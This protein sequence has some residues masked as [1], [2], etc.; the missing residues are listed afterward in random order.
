MLCCSWC[1]KLQ[2]IFGP[3]LKVL[4][5][6]PCSSAKIPI[7]FGLSPS[8]RLVF[9]DPAEKNEY[10]KSPA[11]IHQNWESI[12]SGWE[13]VSYDGQLIMPPEVLHEIRCLQCHIG[14]GCLSGVAPGRGTNLNERL[15]RELNTVLHSSLYGVELDLLPTMF[16]AHNENI[17]A[18]SDKRAPR[19]ISAYTTEAITCRK[20]F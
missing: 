13:G 14:R 5:P 3:Q 11:V 18:K 12:K 10:S 9:R 19:P 1:T 6:F 17:A 15:H 16:Y 8:L 4:G 20:H 7:S 2:N